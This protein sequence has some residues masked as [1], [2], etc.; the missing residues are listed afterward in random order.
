MFLLCF[1]SLMEYFCL[2]SFYKSVQ[3]F[4]LLLV[5]LDFNAVQT[6]NLHSKIREEKNH[7]RRQIY[8]QSEQR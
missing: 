4:T 5:L 7:H 1:T 3:I 2:L 6:I 8:V